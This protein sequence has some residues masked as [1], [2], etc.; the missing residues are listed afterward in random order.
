M[1]VYLFI[2]KFWPHHTACRTLVPWPVLNTCPLHWKLDLTIVLPGKSPVWRSY[3]K[4]NLDTKACTENA[5]WTLGFTIIRQAHVRVCIHTH[6]HTPWDKELPEARRETWGR[7][8]SCTCR[9]S[10]A[11][12][13]PWFWT[14][15]SRIVGIS[16]LF[17]MPHSWWCF[18][19]TVLEN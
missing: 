15:A 6:T 14:L 7:S 2:Y 8:F 11:L 19:K 17:F 13:T 12:P 18:V 9:G 3:E 4:W 1:V 16:C 10:A 5:L